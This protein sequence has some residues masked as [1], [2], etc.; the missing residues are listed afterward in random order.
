MRILFLIGI[1]SLQLYNPQVSVMSKSNQF[2]NNSEEKSEVTIQSN[3][4][5]EQTDVLKLELRLPTISGLSDEA[6][7]DEINKGIVKQALLTKVK[8]MHMA[9]EGEKLADEQGREFI[10]YELKVDYQV[11]NTH[12]ILS[13]LVSTYEYT[14]GAHG[15]TNTDYYNILIDE[16]KTIKL[17]D[18]FKEGSNY[19]EVINTSILKQIKKQEAAGEGSYFHPNEA[20]VGD[21]AFQSIS[22]D[23]PF[24]I[25]NGNL[26][27]AFA[28]YEIAPGY[29][30]QPTF[31]IPMESLQS[32]MKEK[33]QSLIVN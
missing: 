12:E 8:V 6:F 25:E 10:P 3:T 30:G 17:S 32:I 29:M 11:K 7:Q 20:Y 4:I 5:N 2:L 21:N 14:G 1:I 22:E 31:S 28:Q 27:V 23:Q 18:L 13:F 24:Y 15:M 16:N 9:N 19:K 26:V 33:Y